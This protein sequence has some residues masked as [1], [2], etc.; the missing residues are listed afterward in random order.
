MVSIIEEM[1]MYVNKYFH[2]DH[3]HFTSQ[4]KKSAYFIFNLRCSSKANTYNII[5]HI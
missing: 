2:R 4:Y 5:K 3:C 1:M